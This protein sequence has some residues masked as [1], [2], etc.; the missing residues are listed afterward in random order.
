MI[1]QHNEETV[2]SKQTHEVDED[3]T[4]EPSFRLAKDLLLPARAVTE[5]LA[6]L[7]R[8]GSGKSYAA[9]LLAEEMLSERAQ[10]V[11]LDPVGNW[12]G[13]RLN[14]DGTPSGL[15][16]PVFGGLH[17]DIPLEPE[18]GKMLADLV[19]DRGISCV[20]D[21]S[22]MR[23]HHRKEFATEFAEELFHKVKRSRQPLHLFIEEAQVF[24]PQRTEHGE[25]R[26][27]GAFEDLVKLGR[28]FGVGASL[29]SQR[30]QAVNKDVLNQAELLVCL[31]ISGPQER[32]AIETWVYDKGADEDLID[33]LPK[34]ATGEAV[35]WSP[36]WLRVFK[37]VKI[38]KKK[39]LDASATPKFGAAAIEPRELA[40]IDLEQIREAMSAVVKRAEE[41]DPKKLRARIAELES[42]RTVLD[43]SDD[44]QRQVRDAIDA[45]SKEI[46]RRE[47]AERK[48]K[49]IT[50]IARAFAG[51][52]GQ[53][54]DKIK[55]NVAAFWIAV[56]DSF[57]RFKT[58]SVGSL[59]GDDEEDNPVVGQAIADSNPIERNRN[60]VTIR[61][62]AKPKVE[63]LKAGAI[64]M[65]Q[66]LA[67]WS[68]QTMTR[69]QV[70]TLSG[71]AQ[72]GTFSNYISALKASGYVTETSG[73][74]AATKAGIKSLN[75]NYPKTPKTTEELVA[76]WNPKLKA[77]AR[78]MLR[79]LVDAYPRTMSRVVLGE[80]ADVSQGG[81]FSNYLGALRSNQLAEFDEAG[82]VRAARALFMKRVGEP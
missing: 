1:A 77:G 37:R 18:S 48:V 9:Q 30:P 54:S 4:A 62:G 40:P 55:T 14:A 33:D 73:E 44:Y 80:K 67:S 72:G 69:A 63:G 11:V 43:S 75:G 3:V 36:A 21:V 51:D 74:I 20:L 26:M 65:L 22:M 12:Y 59:S 31:Q 57:D 50:D 64:R 6:F 49:E 25:A 66:A 81:T 38:A 28:N 23:K 17:G 29:I 13:L 61:L 76:M 24:V 2:L 53:S 15:D 46:K 70:A 52:V 78:R 34:L 58:S 35:V 79:I 27:L 8:T 60:A 45:L 42:A 19:V 82:N 68:P 47:Q 41:N 32:K 10:I 7:G 71:I 5:K 16:I 56:D 39:T